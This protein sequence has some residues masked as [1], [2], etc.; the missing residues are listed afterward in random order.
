MKILIIIFIY[1]N[2]N[3]RIYVTFIVFVWY[4]IILYILIKLIFKNLRIIR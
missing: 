3:G 2:F 1:E 4:I